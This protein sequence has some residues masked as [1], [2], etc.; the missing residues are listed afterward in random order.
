MIGNG[1][2]DVD[3]PLSVAMIDALGSAMS[4]LQAMQIGQ[5]IAIPSQALNKAWDILVAGNTWHDRQN[6]SSRLP[7]VS[8]V[9]CLC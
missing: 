7:T 4:M 2:V 3:Q 9:I 1:Q 6:L 8:F 5:G